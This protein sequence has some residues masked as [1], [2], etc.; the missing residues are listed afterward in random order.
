MLIIT[1]NFDFDFVFPKFNYR[2]SCFLLSEYVCHVF[3]R[4]DRLACV[5]ISDHEYPETVGF[6]LMKKVSQMRQKEE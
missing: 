2:G 4:G 1:S 3:V 5:L 6:S